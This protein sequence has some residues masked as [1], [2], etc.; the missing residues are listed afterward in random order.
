MLIFTPELAGE[1]DALAL[2]DEVLEHVDIIQVR[3]KALGAD[4][5]G[6]CEARA[7][8]VWARRVLELVARRPALDIP[9]LVDDRVD[10]ALALRPEGLAGV[11]LGQSD[12]PARVARELLG[13]DALI[14]L[15]TTNAQ[16]V[17]EASETGV[18]Y[19]GYGPTFA[20]PTKGYELGRGAEGAWVASQASGVPLFAIG[21]ID[22]SNV[23][24]L[25]AVRRIAVGS[26][27]LS[28]RDPALAAERIRSLLLED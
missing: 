24:Q 25:G 18:D 22:E 1:R 17:A 16:Q 7:A 14:G 26:A 27:I 11:H 21:G 6:P 28:A 15:S 9:V 10:V 23:C 5:S 20:S 19:L 8:L 13:Q 2:L 12:T 4:S 3:P